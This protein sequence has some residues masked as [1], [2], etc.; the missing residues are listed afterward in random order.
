MPDMK[1]LT[2][3]AL[4]GDSASV[5][6]IHYGPASDADDPRFTN[7]SA[8]GWGTS[9]FG[10]DPEEFMAA[11]RMMTTTGADMAAENRSL[12]VAKDRPS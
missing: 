11:R 8:L 1:A 6:D 4:E 3:A 9:N 2:P 12:A 7:T 10:Q 5:A